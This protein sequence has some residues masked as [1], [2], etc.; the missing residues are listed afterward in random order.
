MWISK[1]KWK[2]IEKRI[3]TVEDG[4]KMIRARLR[5]E[6]KDR[7][8]FAKETVKMRNEPEDEAVKIVEIIRDL[9]WEM[10]ELAMLIEEK[11][12]NE[13]TIHK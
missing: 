8:K 1:R 4:Y 9:K 7:K 2:E 11:L 6:N 5:E 10:P 13:K 3:V 12:K